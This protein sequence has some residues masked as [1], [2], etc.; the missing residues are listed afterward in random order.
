MRSQRRRD[1]GGA[2]APVVA[3]QD[4]AFDVQQ[5][6]GNVG[7][8]VDVVEEAVQQT[9]AGPLGSPLSRYATFRSPASTS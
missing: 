1:A 9:T 5:R 4:G 8:R 2:A 3:G 6:R 7:V